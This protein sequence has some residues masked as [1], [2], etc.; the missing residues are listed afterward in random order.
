MSND[1]M[2]LRTMHAL[3][4]MFMAP[5][6][7]QVHYEITEAN[8][9]ST[10]ANP[11]RTTIT[12]RNGELIDVDLYQISGGCWSAKNADQDGQC[13]WD[14]TRE[15]ALKDLESLCNDEIEEAL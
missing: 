3:E 10:L 12:L 5:D 1:D 7:A 9:A 2:F 11:E 8:E 15:L 13:G 4:A 14:A 6:P